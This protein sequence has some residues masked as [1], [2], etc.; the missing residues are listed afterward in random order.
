MTTRRMALAGAVTF[1]TLLVGVTPALASDASR[2]ASLKAHALTLTAMPTGW[3]GGTVKVNTHGSP[4]SGPK[5]LRQIE[6]PK[7]YTTITVTF[8][9][10]TT[11]PLF[12]ESLAV[13]PHEATVFRRLA[14]VLASC[15]SFTFS[16][17][18]TKVHGTF[19]KI[20][21]PRVAQ[22]SE[23]FRMVM[24]SHGISFS[25][26]AVMFRTAAFLGLALYGQAGAVDQATAKGLTDAAVAKAS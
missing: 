5:C 8:H 25:F 14:G 1:L 13:G 23:A 4:T 24:S 12:T 2:I 3:L 10:K 9:A 16:T 21:F 19:T 7:G 22:Q 15:H 26:D 17:S 18:G 11:F 6:P 20:R